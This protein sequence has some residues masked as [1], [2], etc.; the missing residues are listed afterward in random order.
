MPRRKKVKGRLVCM[1][2]MESVFGII[3]DIGV[4]YWDNGK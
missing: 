3:G 2:R 1:A 4:K